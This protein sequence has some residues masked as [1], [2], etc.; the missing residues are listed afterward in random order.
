MTLIWVKRIEMLTT[1]H[2]HSHCVRV[3][4]VSLRRSGSCSKAASSRRVN[5]DAATML[6]KDRRTWRKYNGSAKYLACTEIWPDSIS[7]IRHF[8][9]FRILRIKQTGLKIICFSTL[10]KSEMR[11]LGAG[12]IRC[13]STV[14]ASFFVFVVSTK[15]LG[16]SS[17][18]P[19]KVVN[20]PP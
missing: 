19:L 16:Q 2:T 15:F 11:A 17:P 4:M 8:L 18:R 10:S 13:I 1:R 5:H 20:W 14:V 9:I 12:P 3:S 7:T 6:Q